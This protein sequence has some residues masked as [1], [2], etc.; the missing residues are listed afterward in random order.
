[1]VQDHLNQGL[2]W[3]EGQT[4]Y[5]LLNM[6]LAIEVVCNDS[7]YGAVVPEGLAG[8]PFDFLVALKEP[9][10]YLLHGITHN[11]PTHSNLRTIGVV[12]PAFI[13]MVSGLIPRSIRGAGCFAH[14]YKQ[15]C[16]QAAETRTYVTSVT[17]IPL[18]VTPRNVEL[19]VF[20]CQKIRSWLKQTIIIGAKA[21][22]AANRLAAA[23]KTIFELEI[24]DLIKEDS[25][26]QGL[27]LGAVEVTFDMMRAGSK[28]FDYIA[29]C[30]ESNMIR[31]LLNSGNLLVLSNPGNLRDF[32]VLVSKWPSMLAF[33]IEDCYD[34]SNL[35]CYVSLILCVFVAHLIKPSF[36]YFLLIYCPL[37]ICSSVYSGSTFR[38]GCPF[39][40]PKPVF[41]LAI[42]PSWRGVKCFQK[43]AEATVPWFEVFPSPLS[44]KQNLMIF[45]L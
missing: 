16:Q 11:F 14:V 37:L 33:N 20:L 19:C 32:V 18:S 29:L 12:F 25:T 8:I 22:V 45:D 27:V 1:M 7:T 17:T 31:P 36:V 26:V 23:G 40:G 30:C 13:L 41:A 21:A 39:G 35:S 9:L 6:L 4:L 43:V 15:Q 38:L 3:L 34:Q 28:V 10:G 24:A 42:S 2:K 5:H 44:F